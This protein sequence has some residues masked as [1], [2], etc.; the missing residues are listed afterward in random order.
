LANRIQYRYQS[1]CVVAIAALCTCCPVAAVIWVIALLVL[2]LLFV[3]CLRELLLLS[4]CQTDGV[5]EES[6]RKNKDEL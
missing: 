1:G 4:D 3:V 5:V 6:A 2:D